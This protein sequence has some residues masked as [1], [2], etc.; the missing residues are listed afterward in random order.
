MCIYSKSHL[1]SCLNE[2]LNLSF[3]L[4]TLRLH[5]WSCNCWLMFSETHTLARPLGKAWM[6]G[7]LLFGRS[8]P[9]TLERVSWEHG[10]VSHTTFPI[11]SVIFSGGENN[12]SVPVNGRL[13][14]S[15]YLTSPIC[16]DRNLMFE[17]CLRVQN[18]TA[19]LEINVKYFMHAY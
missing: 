8:S 19:G 15:L 16:A 6:K 7:W 12:R 11:V 1:L 10:S 2:T 17:H 9:L 13:R 5:C 14:N 18:D 4:Q 3:S